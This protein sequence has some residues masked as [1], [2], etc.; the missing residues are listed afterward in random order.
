MDA[1]V[2]IGE[3]P[4]SERQRFGNYRW[5]SAHRPAALKS[6]IPVINKQKTFSSDGTF[7]HPANLGWKGVALKGGTIDDDGRLSRLPQ[8]STKRLEARKPLLW[9][10]DRDS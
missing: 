3:S 7:Q 5:E 4:L 1:E 9:Q 8:Y 10:V 6:R 2:E